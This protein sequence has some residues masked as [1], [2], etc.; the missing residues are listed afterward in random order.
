MGADARHERAVDLAVA[1]GVEHRGGRPVLQRQGAPHVAAA[2]VVDQ[3]AAVIAVGAGVAAALR[4][5]DRVQ[6]QIELRAADRHHLAVARDIQIADERAVVAVGA[7]RPCGVADRQRHGRGRVQGDHAGVVDLHVRPVRPAAAEHPTRRVAPGIDVFAAGQRLELGSGQ[8][9]AGV[10][11]GLRLAVVGP[12]LRRAG[13]D[14]NRRPVVADPHAVAEI[15]DWVV[16]EVGV[17]AGPRGERAGARQGAGFGV[18]DRHQLGDALPGARAVAVGA[19]LE[20]MHRPDRADDVEVVAAPEPA[21]AG[22]AVFGRRADHDHAVRH[23]DR[24]SEPGVGVGRVA[25]GQRGDQFGALEDVGRARR[26]VAVRRR[27]A[28]AD[29]RQRD[30]VGG[31]A[32]VVVEARLDRVV[33][34]DQRAGAADLLVDDGA[35]AAPAVLEVEVARNPQL[36]L[37]DHHLRDRVAAKGNPRAGRHR[38][39]GRHHIVR[40]VLQ[41]H[42]ELEVGRQ[43]RARWRGRGC[44]NCRCRRQQR[45]QTQQPAPLTEGGPGNRRHTQSSPLLLVGARSLKRRSARPTHSG[46]RLTLQAI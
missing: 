23:I 42:R 6:R 10:V 7:L 34:A 3:N 37:G 38:G 24:L 29:H 26:G 32:A 35:G 31:A 39:F 30:R 11:A 16:L 19:L 5:G 33:F 44:H 46:A 41:H 4:S 21:V 43:L 20:D 1:G 14:R 28:R 13:V 22:G 18:I 8:R 12:D 25:R 40:V 17:E 15:G 27:V 45:H 9:R 2:A 36:R